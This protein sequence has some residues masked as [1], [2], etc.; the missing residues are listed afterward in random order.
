MTRTA[1][2]RREFWMPH[3]ALM[4]IGLMRAPWGDPLVR[5]FEEQI[6]DVFA[7]AA[8]SPG[9]VA[10]LGPVRRGAMDGGP[11][12]V[13]PPFAAPQDEDRIAQTCSVWR[14]AES[15]F[16]FSYRGIHGTA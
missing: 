1:R 2:A 11:L 14:D 3:V 12:V 16:T 7:T 15:A 6:D 4:T 13:P 8:T 5:G 9:L 10:R